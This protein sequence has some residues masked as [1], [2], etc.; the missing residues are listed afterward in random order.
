MPG[1]LAFV[2]VMSTVAPR[3]QASAGG[4]RQT[5]HFI[6]EPE[7][8]AGAVAV[9]AVELPGRLDAPATLFVACGEAEAL[10]VERA[11]HG[12]CA[13]VETLAVGLARDDVHRA[14]HGVRA[15]E[16][17][18]RTLDNLH[19][20]HPVGHVRVGQSVSEHRRP[21]RLTVDHEQHLVALAHATD[22]YRARGAAAD[23]V[24]RKATLR[25]EQTCHTVCK[26]RQQRTLGR[27]VD[28]RVGNHRHIERQQLYARFHRR[29]YLHLLKLRD[30][31]SFRCLSRCCRAQHSNHSGYYKFFSMIKKILVY[32]ARKD[33]K[34]I[35]LANL[36]KTA[37]L[38]TKLPAH[39][40]QI[41]LRVGGKHPRRQVVRPQVGSQLA[42]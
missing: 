12:A 2:C 18:R 4:V 19:T 42:R 16:Q 7:V 14:A 3:F 41:E 27:I 1:L 22:V 26:N 40:H 11:E 9:A 32:L 25:G 8:G 21:L 24:A 34:K 23:A 30:T 15:V 39:R 20:F 13:A 5:Y 6:G 38:A 28:D 10:R 37:K 36:A 33:N 29:R 35:K 17:R 31:G